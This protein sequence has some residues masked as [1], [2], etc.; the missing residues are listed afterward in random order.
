VKDSK[1]KRLVILK[2]K[3]QATR[4]FALKFKSL[5]NLLVNLSEKD[6]KLHSKSIKFFTGSISDLSQIILSKVFQ[7]NI[8]SQHQ[9]KN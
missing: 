9:D 6:S 7:I 4:K 2:T 8:L 3:C 5:E 1:W